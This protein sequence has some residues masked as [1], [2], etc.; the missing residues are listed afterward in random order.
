MPRE[1]RATIDEVAAYLR[2]SPQTLRNWRTAG[3]GPQA[4]KVGGRLRYDW[5]DV[6]EWERRGSD[7]R[8]GSA[9]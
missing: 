2:L 5:R 3:T 6:E 7:R 9:A 8:G 4:R 1:P